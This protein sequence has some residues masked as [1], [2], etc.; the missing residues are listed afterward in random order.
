MVLPFQ[1]RY[2]RSR[3]H[4]HRDSLVRTHSLAGGHGLHQE[5]GHETSMVVTPMVVQVQMVWIAIVLRVF[6]VVLARREVLV[7]VEGR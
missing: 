4:S 6:A 7:G 2:S 5:T 3:G 1:G